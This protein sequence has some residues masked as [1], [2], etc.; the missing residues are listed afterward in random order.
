MLILLE[1]LFTC[2][3]HV[4]LLSI[5]SPR[6]I[7]TVICN[8]RLEIVWSGFYAQPSVLGSGMKTKT[9]RKSVSQKSEVIIFSKKLTF[10]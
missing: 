3:V 7:I 9:L 5:V 2:C 4:K 6:K 1:R 10:R 8:L